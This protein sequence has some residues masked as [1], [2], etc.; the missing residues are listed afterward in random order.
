[1]KLFF[2]NDTKRLPPVILTPTLLLIAISLA[3]SAYKSAGSQPLT[4]GNTQAQTSP[5]TNS[6]STTEE[7]PPCTLT[8]IGAATITGVRLGM[9]ADEVLA[10]FPGSKSDPAVSAALSKP[11]SQFGTLGFAIQPG[12]YLSKEAQAQTPEGGI[13]RI[14]FTLL[15]GRVWNFT[16]AYNGPEWPHVD[17]FVS[18]FIE[19]TSL[20]PVDQ[21]RP[22]AGMESQ[23]KVLSCKEFEVR[24]FSGGQ[25]G[26][27]NY[28]LV[29][30]LV[31]E[32]KLKERR[33]KAAAEATPPAQ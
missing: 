22:Y 31:A 8:L 13:T 15:D 11:V 9:T 14:N 1:M 16:A 10:L 23:L 2:S 19:G 33:E 12:K 30:D 5:Q 3:C 18:K 27:L 17:K 21:W 6:S 32:K 7:T 20:P 28:V 25:G 29:R 26:N 24:V 4:N